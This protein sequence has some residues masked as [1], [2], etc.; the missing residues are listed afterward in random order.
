MPP[1]QSNYLPFLTIVAT[2]SLVGWTALGP[3]VRTGASNRVVTALDA[4]L[5]RDLESAVEKLDRR[6]QVLWEGEKIAPAEP[7]DELQVLRRLSLALVGTVPSLAEIREFEADTGPDRLR[8]WTVRLI[9]DQRFS[10]HFS[11]RLAVAF[12]GTFE[13][14]VPWFSHALFEAW[15]ADQLARGRPYDEM[16]RQIITETGPP[17]S[18]GAA[19]FVTAEIVQ[20]EQSANRLASRAARAF[21]GQRIDCAECHDHPF[22]DWKQA[23]FQGLAAYFAQVRTGTIGILD[24][25]HR[26][27]EVED[28]T[29][30]EKHVIEPRVP[31]HAEWLGEHGSRRQQLAGWITHRE[32]RRF[33]RAISNRIWGLLFGRPL[34]APVDSI[35]DPREPLDAHDS[36]EPKQ[37]DRQADRTDV[38]DLL[39]A[40]LREHGGDLR[41]L[42]LVIASSHPFRMVST[43]PLL[44]TAS[45]TDCERLEKTWAV[46]PLVPLRPE[47]LARSLEQAAS[48]RPLPADQDIV[49]R[50][51]RELWMRAFVDQY[52]SL[53]EHELDDRTDSIPQTM[54]RMH[55]RFTREKSGAGWTNAAGRIAAIAPDDATALDLC[56]LVCLTRRPTPIER[57]HFLLQFR[58][59]G[60]QSR[61]R[62]VEDIFWTLFSSPEFGWNH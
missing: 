27:H 13:Q 45:G 32:N 23:D 22:D 59:T 15:L 46:F 58:G 4:Q 60:M 62:I 25:A 41:R 20:G 53:D 28:R 56:Y 33:L 43:H 29:T 54:H 30:L 12:A 6:F 61:P 24:D 50:T 42:V 39:A 7:A 40:D 18:H 48:L 3:S 44:E 19:N 57:D 9:A 5:G 8:R 21:L 37:V 36:H 11:E 26:Q 55:S 52:G 31:F 34:V 17:T 38:L 49:T 47:Q 51:R 16:V 1:F 2:S 14:K 35:P 10:E